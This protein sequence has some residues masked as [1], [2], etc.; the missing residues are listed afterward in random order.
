MPPGLGYKMMQTVSAAKWEASQRLGRGRPGAA[1]REKGVW[2][3]R[4]GK[5]PW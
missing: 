2:Q 4:L 1:G 5:E 3:P